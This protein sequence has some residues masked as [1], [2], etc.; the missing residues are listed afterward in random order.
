MKILALHVSGRKLLFL[1]K[2]RT[3]SPCQTTY[4]L[5]LVVLDAP[6]EKVFL[7]RDTFLLNRGLL[8]DH[9]TNT[10]VSCALFCTLG[11]QQDFPP[12]IEDTQWIFFPTKISCIQRQSFKQL[13]LLFISFL[14]LLPCRLWGVGCVSHPSWER[15][16]GTECHPSL[17]SWWHFYPTR[18]LV[19]WLSVQHRHSWG[20][21]EAP[22]GL[23]MLSGAQKTCEGDVQRASLWR[24]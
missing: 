16:Q 5:I 14:L 21:L 2:K 7:F 11:T 24:I 19:S 23:W 10:T 22:R 15:W 4:C 8:Q 20:G 17:S 13:K 3:K 12:F 9:N 1:K 6:F 18:A